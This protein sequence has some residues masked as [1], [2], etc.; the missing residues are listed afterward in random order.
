[1]GKGLSRKEK[2]AIALTVAL[3][4][5]ACAALL[6]ARSALAAGNHITT[7]VVEYDT[8][9]TTV[10]VEGLII[11]QELTVP[12]PEAGFGML[13]VQDGEKLAKGDTVAVSYATADRLEA[14][15][16]AAR[17]RAELELYEQTLASVSRDSELS[18]I[19][20]SLY[21][22][23]LALARAS[24]TGFVDAAASARA[25]AG[26]LGRASV[27]QP[28][29]DLAGRV[30]ALGR[31]YDRLVTAA[32]KGTVIAAPAAGYYSA[33]SDGYPSA[34][35][36]ENAETLTTESFAQALALG[37]QPSDANGM[38]SL[39][40]GYSWY[41]ACLAE[42]ERCEGLR[43]G[44]TYELSFADFSVNARLQ[45]LGDA[46]DGKR[47]CLF[48]IEEKIEKAVSLREASA[49]LVFGEVSGYRIPKAALRMLEGKRG[50]YVI[51][52]QRCVFMEIEILLEKD[53]YYV[54]KADLTDNS[55]LFLNDT[56]V[57]SGKDLYDGMVI[58]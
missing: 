14:Y 32:G 45:T 16:E 10:P 49:E 11:R 40:L 26:M 46:V 15:R 41:Y 39:V 3:M 55:G 5:L 17:V 42:Q 20:E 30:E 24:A 21:E 34:L 28:D 22:A 31:E 53:N 6:I 48:C 51:R 52:G 13:T 8:V 50:V 54:V 57:L 9:R 33:V 37:K 56:L 29:Y 58:Q 23:K 7:T 35:R 19:N 43:Q 1:M 4:A 36:Y 44:R 2:T 47:L 38:G 27:L 18:G 25:L 12:A